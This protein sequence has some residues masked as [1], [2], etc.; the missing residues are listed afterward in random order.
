MPLC[1]NPLSPLI[2]I[3][4]MRQSRLHQ[5]RKRLVMTT[6]LLQTWFYSLDSPCVTP[7]KSTSS[8]ASSSCLACI[9]I[10]PLLFF[11]FSPPTPTPRKKHSACSFLRVFAHEDH[12]LLS[13]YIFLFLSHTKQR[14]SIIYRISIFHT[15]PSGPSGLQKLQGC[16]RWLSSTLCPAGSVR[17]YSWRLRLLYSCSSK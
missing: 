3:I 4:L 11:L 6:A 16:D 13:F 14:K 10:F 12:A 9:L 5:E 15:A 2:R 1:S 8:M 17:F 7:H